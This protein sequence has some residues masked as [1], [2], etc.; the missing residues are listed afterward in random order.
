MF[1]TG[2]HG[3]VGPTGDIYFVLVAERSRLPE[4]DEVVLDE[5]GQP[6]EVRQIHSAKGTHV[7]EALA[8]VHMT[9][10]NAEALATWLLQRVEER[11]RRGHRPPAQPPA[12]TH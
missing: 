5:H 4:A 1:V 3:G 11:K 6:L 12:P 7:R 8:G 2:A 10:E 9:V